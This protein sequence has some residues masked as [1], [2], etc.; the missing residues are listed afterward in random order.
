MEDTAMKKKYKKPSVRIIE[1]QHK[2]QILAGSG[3]PTRNVPWWDGEAG[4]R[5]FN[6]AWDDEDEWED[7]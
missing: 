7:E 4:A 1:L 2:C 5:K 6:G 3:D